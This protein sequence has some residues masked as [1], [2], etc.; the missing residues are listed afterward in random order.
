ML[1]TRR[2]LRTMI[3]ATIKIKP[4]QSFLNFAFSFAFAAFIAFFFQYDLGHSGVLTLFILIFA[5]GLWIT[6]AIPAFAVALLIVGLEIIL[7]GFDGFD[8]SDRSRWESYLA[9]WSNPLVFLFLA[10]FI[11]ALAASKTKLDIWLAKKVLFFVGGKPLHIAFGIMGITFLLSMFISNTATAAMMITILSPI[12]LAI[13]EDNPFKKA[14]LLAVV[15]GANLGG[16]STIIG[17]PPNAIAVGFLGAEAPSFVGW[18]VLA[19]PPAMISAAILMSIMIKIYPSDQSYISLKKLKG[20]EDDTAR[21]NRKKPV[22]VADW[23]KKVVIVIFLLTVGL[24]L[25]G[26]LHQIPTTVVS[27]LPIVGFT[28]FGIIDADDIRQ[29]RWDVI[30]LIIGGL[31]L[32]FAVTQNGVDT[33]IADM[34]PQEGISAVAVI[35]IFSYLVVAVSNFMSNTAATNIILPIAVAIGASYSPGDGLTT[36]VAVALSASFAMTLPVSTP[37]N[38]IVYSSGALHSRQF[39]LLGLFAAAIGPL[40]IFAWLLLATSSGWVI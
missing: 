19:M 23:K 37:P 34:V 21:T 26:P 38:A 27:F 16:M 36:A 8:F 9:P 15:I 14:M 35:V 7:L 4:A 17:T 2:Y 25:T 6:E 32:G 22:G 1:D 18:M 39:L 13:K 3:D 40:L 33:W 10:G 31:S 11:M 12:L 29:V 28:L 20:I 5:A 30:I 24:W